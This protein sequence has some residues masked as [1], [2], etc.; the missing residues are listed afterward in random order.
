MRPNH[1][2]RNKRS[3]CFL[4]A[5]LL[6]IAAGV[7]L[8]STLAI[9]LGFVLV[10]FA[11]RYRK[12]PVAW[13]YLC[14]VALALAVVAW[15]V[16]TGSKPSPLLGAIPLMWSYVLDYLDERRQKRAVAAEA[17]VTVGA[18]HG[19]RL[20]YQSAPPNGGPATRSLCWDSG[21]HRDTGF[22]SE[23][24]T[25]QT[26][27]I[28]G[29]IN[30]YRKVAFWKL[31]GAVALASIGIVLWSAGSSNYEFSA[32]AFVAF[33]FSFIFALSMAISK[34]TYIY[35]DFTDR[36]IV[37][38]EHY[39]W[40]ETSKRCRPLTDFTNIVVRHLCHPGG[41]EEDTYT[42]SVGLKPVDGRAVL[43]VKSFPTTQ[44]EVPRTAH[45]FARKL[46]EMTGLLVAPGGEFKNET[47]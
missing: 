44:D 21:T 15:N 13:E 28:Q 24:T 26:L 18:S 33:G 17:A 27:D 30:S 9:Y 8:G 2:T 5:A 20:A 45:E 14:F 16:S 11:V 37:T 7:A 38:V 25:K 47:Q 41:E 43:W 31:G 19:G 12:E 6:L 36:Q 29:T 10:A 46:Q 22:M 34:D 3:L 32:M 40:I 1:A 23:P 39:A 35:L 4:A 42:G